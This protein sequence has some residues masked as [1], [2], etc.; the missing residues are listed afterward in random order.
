MSIETFFQENPAL[1]VALFADVVMGVSIVRKILHPYVGRF[2]IALVLEPLNSRKN[3]KKDDDPT[4][5]K[6]EQL[7]LNGEILRVVSRVEFDPVKKKEFTIGKGDDAETYRIE[8]PGESGAR[9][10]KKGE[11]PV[12]ESS[13]DSAQD[14]LD[15]PGPGFLQWTHRVWFFRRGQAYPI[16][17]GFGLPARST[18]ATAYDK[19][20][21]L[22]LW[23]QSVRGARNPIPKTP[24]GMSIMFLALGAA[25]TGALFFAIHPGFVP[26]SSLPATTAS[27]TVNGTGS[28]TSTITFSVSSSSSGAG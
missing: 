27:H 26:I 10:R 24:I 22:K 12:A 20:V 28:I 23:E 2:D 25:I 9:E 6:D 16:T 11:E 21:R 3:G 14:D 8:Q 1:L 17:T 5:D 13:T 4:T 18:T 15:L 7:E 19:V